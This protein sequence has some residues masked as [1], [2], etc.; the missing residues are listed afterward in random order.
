MIILKRGKGFTD[1]MRTYKVLL[2]G[3]EIG[4]IRQG[5]LMQFSV[6]EGKHTL[7]LKIDWCT[8]KPVTFELTQQ[9]I[10]FECGSNTAI[11]AIFSAFFK[12]MSIYGSIELSEQGVSNH[13]R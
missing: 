5:D 7:Q 6:P 13:E 8:S 11:K 12:K 10:T 1:K 2:D 3:T 9:P 4:K